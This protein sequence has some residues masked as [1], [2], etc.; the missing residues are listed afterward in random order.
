MRVVELAGAV[1][2]GKSTMAPVVVE[3][4]RTRGHD[5]MTLA[6]AMTGLRGERRRSLVDLPSGLVFAVRHPRLVGLVGAQLVRAPLTWAHR[7][8]ILG[9]V[10][11][12]GARQRYLARH[13]PA[14]RVVVVDEGF[15]QRAVNVF[16]WLP[17][18]PR[19][20]D[21]ARYVAL[22]PI[23]D[24]VVIV[25]AEH[26]VATARAEARGLPASVRARTRE[27]AAGFLARGVD[28]IERVVPLITSTRASVVELDNS[29]AANVTRA[30]LA[31]RL[32]MLD[33]Q[34]TDGAGPP[35]ASLGRLRLPRP[36]RHG[37]PAT[38]SE[39]D[40]AALADAIR[41]FGFGRWR[42]VRPL[43]RAGGR[44]GS[45]LIATAAGPVVVK[46]YKPT[47]DVEQVRVEH[48]VLG[49]LERRQFPAP[50]LWRTPE[51]GTFAASGP[52]IFAAFRYVAGYRRPDD[53]LTP[54]W[55]ARRRV[56]AHGEA[57]GALHAS[58]TGFVP[59][60]PG[61]L[62]FAT[63]DGPRVRDAAWHLALLDRLPAAAGDLATRDAV[64]E[65]RRELPA[66]EAA[67]A[68][69]APT[70][71]IVHGDY[72]PYNLLVR[73][74]A[75]ILIVDFELARLD[76]RITDLATAQSRFSLAGGQGAERGMAA[77]LEGYR[78]RVELSAA[79]VG[80]LGPV[81]AFL[82]LR[83]AAV[84]V[85]R[86]AESHRPALRREARDK[87]L[88]ART[89]LAGQHPIVRLADAR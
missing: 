42:L 50:R 38:F 9:L 89:I 33:T 78:R 84:C 64:S 16:G 2:A 73:D 40:R 4:L 43:G 27:D 6:D 29:G 10:I 46:R 37:T 77:L 5:A 47:V 67:L 61:P 63:V 25:R 71:G 23:G 88:L 58:L 75:P 15:V 54:P 1:G 59:P 12:L 41:A 60:V 35:V 51:G 68:V 65:L 21:L 82:S 7:S 53:L 28:V 17:D 45:V 80:L 18:G 55:D 85:A 14:G 32:P 57:L 26:G 76:W 3:I 20:A 36:R 34:R 19:P 74:G 39:N 11:R 8:R 69:A 48:A 86:A 70:R 44:S 62:G 79:E 24:V 66:L 87:M 22:A 83:R 72:G 13:V 30:T 49:E 52:G 31:D 81:L 56:M